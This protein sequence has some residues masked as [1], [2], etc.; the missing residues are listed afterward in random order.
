MI[1]RISSAAAAAVAL[2]V[3]LSACAAPTGSGTASSTAEAATAATS[4]TAVDAWVKAAPDGMSAA[5]GELQNAADA[6]VTLVS[7]TTAASDAVELHETVADDSGAMV[8]R[9]VEDGFVISAGGSRMLEPGADHIM[10]MSL[11]APLVA[12]DDVVLT[13]TFDD[14][15]SLDVTA[16]VKDFAGANETYEGDHAGHGDEHSGHGDEHGDEHSGHGDDHSG[17]GD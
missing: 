13:L 11:T 3:M 6:D 9:P 7:V 8:M 14:G 5:F 15:S 10:L 4:V 2:I 12:G 16:P 17:H 1:R